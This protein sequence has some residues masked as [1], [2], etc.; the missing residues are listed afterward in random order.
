MDEPGDT[1]SPPPA[2]RPV[3]AIGGTASPVT[4]D[5]PQPVREW[6]ASRKTDSVLTSLRWWKTSRLRVNYILARSL[7]DLPGVN[8]STN[9]LQKQITRN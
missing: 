8:I 4:S 3:W 7:P 1:D 2:V 6:A 5:Q 9:A